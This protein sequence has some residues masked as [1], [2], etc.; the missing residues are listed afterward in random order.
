M[1][2][3]RDYRRPQDEKGNEIVEEGCA[4]KTPSASPSPPPSPPKVQ[5]NNTVSEEYL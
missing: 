5:T 3:V 2:H 1:D 4:P